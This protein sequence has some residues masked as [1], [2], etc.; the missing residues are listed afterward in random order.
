[1]LRPCFGI[2]A[3]ADIERA[4]TSQCRI[5][6]N[7]TQGILNIETSNEEGATYRLYNVRGILVRQ[8]D[9]KP[10]INLE[11]LP[12]GLYLLQIYYAN[13]QPSI[14]KIMLQ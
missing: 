9:I 14:H 1:M 12:R 8:G 2:S 10:S 3:T 4:Q 6:P 5:Y 7:P 13:A 11:N